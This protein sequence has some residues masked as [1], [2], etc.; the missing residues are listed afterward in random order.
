M[1]LRKLRKN[2]ID[3]ALN[4]SFVSTLYHHVSRHFV[5]ERV[6]LHRALWTFLVPFTR[7]PDAVETI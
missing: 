6:F 5:Y 7:P 4:Y 1:A 2:L 3:D